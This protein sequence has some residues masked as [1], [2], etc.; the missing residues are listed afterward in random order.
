MKLPLVAKGALAG[1]AAMTLMACYGAPE[2]PNWSLED[3][4]D[5]PSIL[6]DADRTNYEAQIEF[7]VSSEALDQ[8]TDTDV[9]VRFELDP[10]SDDTLLDVT[11]SIDGTAGSEQTVLGAENPYLH[12]PVEFAP[13]SCLNDVCTALVDVTFSL[14]AGRGGVLTGAASI[15]VSAYGQWDPPEGTSASVEWVQ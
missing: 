8:A 9:G 1:T 15:Y 2:E 6:L 14:S 5:A 12:I 11:T 4:A 3:N 10:L 13:D 7:T